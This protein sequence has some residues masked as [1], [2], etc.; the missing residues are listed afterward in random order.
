M[1]AARLLAEIGDCRARFPTPE[2]LASL[3]GVTPSTRQSGKMKTTSFR[4]SADKQLR[5]A[6]CD[7]AADSRFAN[8]WAAQL[9][10]QARA[11]GHRHP[12][13]VR[14]VA[15]AWLH[16]IWRCW[17]DHQPYDPARHRALQTLL[18]EPGSPDEATAA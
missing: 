11:R 8:P 15:R 9:Y 1:R 12:H 4:W 16:V 3:A 5:D 10:Q 6:V 17:Q 7:F 2:S 13:A 18:H 14:I